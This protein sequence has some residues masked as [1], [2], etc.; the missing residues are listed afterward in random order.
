MS[1]QNGHI[2]QFENYR[3][4]FNEKTLHRDETIVPL[5]P[6]V[7]ETLHLF[8]KNAGR[9]VEKD[10]FM[11]ELWQDQFVEE[12]NLT[13]NIKMLRKALG[14]DATHPRFVETV[15]R[16]GYRFIAPV[17]H[18]GSG[19]D[20]HAQ[21]EN[22]AEEQA[23]EA[24][25]LLNFPSDLGNTSIVKKTHAVELPDQKRTIA[26]IAIFVLLAAV[27]GFIYYFYQ[28]KT[29]AVGDKKSIAVLPFK[30][31]NT[32]NRDPLYE[33]G[34]AESLIRRL[35]SIKGFVVRPLSATRQ[36]TDIDQD[37]L[38]AGKEQKVDYVLAS[39]YQLADGKLKSTA[40]LFNV[41]SG[42]I[43]EIKVGEKDAT[44]VFAM[45]DTI[46]GEVANILLARFGLASGATITKRGTTNE[47]AYRLYLQG[48]YSVDKRDPTEARKAIES[49]EHAVLLDPNYAQAWVGLAHAHRVIGGMR[50]SSNTGEEYQQS[51]EAINK[52]LALD[53]NLADAHS[54]LCDNKMQYEWDFDGAERE[55]KRAIELDPNSARAH[56][57]YSRYLHGRGRFDEAIAEIKTAIDIEPASLFSQRIYGSNLYYARRYAEAVTQLKRVIAMDPNFAITYPFLWQSLEMHGNYREA[58]EWFM[59]YQALQKADQETIQVYNNAYQTSGWPGVLREQVKRFENSDVPYF[60]CAVVNAKAGNKDTAFEYLEKS[61]ERRELWMHL[62]K[63][64]P[65]LDALHDDPRFDELVGRVGYK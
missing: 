16:R 39:N 42:Q 23:Q 22:A 56:Q 37:A 62:L 49:F 14:D 34:I 64:E 53:E 65:G 46:A 4:D 27:I 25:N 30:P 5:T 9:L 21:P 40:Q 47:A 36:Y 29:A 41:A 63:V 8:L 7:F 20:R 13:F 6:K 58:F 10:E 35:S 45:Q 12:S 51:I 60:H 31:I 43:E 38:A 48:M 61:F 17:R 1:L 19:E 59:K 2:Y 28:A 26:A 52:A 55:C 33:I 18:V 57:I 15:Q 44:N 50:R 32:A 24:A 54:A 3:L 11:R